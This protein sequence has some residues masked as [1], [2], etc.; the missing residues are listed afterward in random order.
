MLEGD[1]TLL[2]TLG[3]HKEQ[4]EGKGDKP[5]DERGVGGEIVDDVKDE[6]RCDDIAHKYG[7]EQGK[8][9]D[10]ALV[11]ELTEVV[12]MVLAHDDGAQEGGDGQERDKAADDI[13]RPVTEQLPREGE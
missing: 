4:D 1:A 3:G 8:A 12:A 7:K 5:M 13:A 11:P 9:I 2:D 10:I 6:A